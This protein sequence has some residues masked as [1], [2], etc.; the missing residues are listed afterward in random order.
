MKILYL[1][2]DINLSETVA[3]FLEDEGFEVICAYDGEE[4]LEIAYKEN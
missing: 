2:D 4:A 1:E 3:E